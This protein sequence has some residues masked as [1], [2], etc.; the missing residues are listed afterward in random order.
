MRWDAVELKGVKKN[1]RTQ[2]LAHACQYHSSGDMRMGVTLRC[3]E[4]KKKGSRKGDRS[5]ERLYADLPI[6]KNIGDKGPRNAN[7]RKVL[8]CLWV[9][10]VERVDD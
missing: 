4:I 5:G 10:G 3:Y 9:H 1:Q 8:V 7:A 6:C 2:G